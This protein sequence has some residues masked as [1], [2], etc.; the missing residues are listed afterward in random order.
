M[1]PDL[2]ITY[3]NQMMED[4]SELELADYCLE[5]GNCFWD[6]IACIDHKWVQ[7]LAQRDLV[8]GGNQG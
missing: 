7:K 2:D 4:L 1:E 6:L 5:T 3:A 8:W